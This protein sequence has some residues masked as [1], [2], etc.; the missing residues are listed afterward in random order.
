[1]V[2]TLEVQPELELQLRREAGRKGLDAGNFVLNLL[3]EYLNV[4]DAA[5]EA[6]S[7]KELLAAVNRGLST[8][9]WE[10]YR[11]LIDK[12]RAETLTSEEHA[13]LIATTTELEEANVFRVR[14]LA[15]L[16]RRR[17]VPL[18]ALMDELGIKPA[19]HG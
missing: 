2:L 18:R 16:A 14:C 6:R 12:R 19:I 7:E 17:Q 9:E 8:E 13:E 1:M 4:P 5:P 10:R 3:R 15:E 11:E